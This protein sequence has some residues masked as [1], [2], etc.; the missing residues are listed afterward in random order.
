MS[1][2]SN[3]RPTD[4]KKYE[5]NYLRIFGQKCPDCHGGGY[6]EKPKQ[7]RHK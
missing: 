6:L 5:R 3:Y 4:Q 1:K 2:G 7:R